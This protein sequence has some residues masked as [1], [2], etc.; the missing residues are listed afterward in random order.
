MPGDERSTVICVIYMYD[1]QTEKTLQKN[2]LQ[3]IDFFK[4]CVYH[5]YTLF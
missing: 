3:M 2:F 4:K 5:V 1:T